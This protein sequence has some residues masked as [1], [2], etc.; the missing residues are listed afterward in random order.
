MERADGQTGTH[1]KVYS[2]A[3]IERKNERAKEKKEVGHK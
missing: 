1:K 2:K 3:H